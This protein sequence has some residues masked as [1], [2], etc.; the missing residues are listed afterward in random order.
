[1]GSNS[2]RRYCIF[3]AGSNSACRP[4]HTRLSTNLT[5]ISLH[6]RRREESVWIECLLEEEGLLSHAAIEQKLNPEASLAGVQEDT[7]WANYIRKTICFNEQLHGVPE[8]GQRSKSR[9]IV[10]RKLSSAIVDHQNKLVDIWL[11]CLRRNG[12]KSHEKFQRREPKSS[13]PSVGVRQNF[14]GQS[15]RNI[16][17][18]EHFHHHVP[19]SR[20]EVL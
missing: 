19:V 3:S 16:R 1:M 11:S 2:A 10:H 13:T 12:L 14:F 7:L 18:R 20:G 6:L 17:V 5:P 9:K 4:H 15:L 8:T